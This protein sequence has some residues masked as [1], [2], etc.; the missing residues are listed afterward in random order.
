[1]HTCIMAHGQGYISL[2]LVL[3]NQ[4]I[5]HKSLCMCTTQHVYIISNKLKQ[6]KNCKKCYFVTFIYGY[7]YVYALFEGHKFV[8]LLFI[9]S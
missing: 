6:N 5:M 9:S 7:A 8:R 2:L 1:M 4:F 3:S